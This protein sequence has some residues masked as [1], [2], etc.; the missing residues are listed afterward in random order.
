MCSGQSPCF[1]GVAFYQF[2]ADPQ[3]NHY[4]PA[5]DKSGRIFRPVHHDI[6]NGNCIIIYTSKN[7]DTGDTCS[8]TE[9]H[10]SDLLSPPGAHFQLRHHQRRST[11]HLLFHH[12]DPVI[13]LRE[14]L[15]LLVL[16]PDEGPCPVVSFDHSPLLQITGCLHHVPPVTLTLK[17]KSKRFQLIPHDPDRTAAT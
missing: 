3:N 1:L 12:P 8:K 16:K 5:I 11:V 6:I 2:Q 10:H 13:N 14:H 9:Q 4:A 7:L 17:P 15:I